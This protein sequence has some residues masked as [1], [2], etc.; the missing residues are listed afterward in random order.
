MNLAANARDAMPSGGKLTIETSVV[1]LDEE[2]ARTH[3]PAVPGRFA[4]VSVSDTG[5]GMSNETQARIF[6]PFFTTKEIGRGTGLGLATV[7]GIVKQSG[8]FIWVYSEVDRGS[9]FK[10]YLPIVEQEASSIE[11]TPSARDIP[12]G[13][14]TVLIVEDSPSVRAVAVT[15]LN[16]LGYKTLEATGSRHAVDISNSR[17]EPIDLLLTDIVMPEMS[18]RELASQL[19]LSR[20]TMRVLFMSGY[21]DDAVMRHGVLAPGTVHLQKPFTPDALALKVRD[22]L[23]GRTDA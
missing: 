11:A 13:T 20:P 23:D 22:V 21:A 19:L 5:V 17:D 3:Y 15:I 14:E 16:R 12:G 7:Y 1:D 2:Y 8:G 9:T 6:E 18:G 10:I 4:L